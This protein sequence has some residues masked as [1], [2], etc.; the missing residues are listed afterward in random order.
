MIFLTLLI[1][2]LLIALGFFIFDLKEIT[3]QEFLIDVCVQI[4]IAAISVACIFH[5]NT[6]DHELLNGRVLY[7]EHH[8]VHCR[9][10]YPCNPYPC[11]CGKNGCSTCWHTCYEHPYDVDW[12]VH[13]NIG[14]WTID[15]IDAQGLEEPPRWTLV[16]VNDPVV[17]PHEYTNYIKGAPNSLFR[18]SGQEADF[19]KYLVPYQ[20]DVYDYYKVDRVFTAGYTLPDK[21]LWNDRLSL[22]NS[23]VGYNK[24]CNIV[25]VFTSLPREYFYA[26][27]QHWIGG[28]KNDVIV[29]MSVVGKKI[30]WADV[31]CWSQDNMLKVKLTDDILNIKTVDRSRILSIIANDTQ[32][33]F[34]R[35]HMKDF[36]YLES[37]ITPSPTQWLIAM[38]IGVLVSIGLNIFFIKAA[39]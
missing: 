37:S 12:N 6:S 11:A 5:M 24:Q 4:A 9:H 18:Y 38:L 31:M 34:V 3:W 1:I 2:P 13:S 7:K 16:Q 26:L 29:V 21:A 30:K 19:K 23:I 39:E 32:K 15:T 33:Y 10:S 28:K 20:Q 36:K 14:E 22:I 25:L 35:R 17:L 27:T 8:H